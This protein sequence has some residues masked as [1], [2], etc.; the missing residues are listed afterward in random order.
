MYLNFKESQPEFKYDY[1]ERLFRK[2]DLDNDGLVDVNLNKY[3]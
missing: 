2:I 3:R 1:Y